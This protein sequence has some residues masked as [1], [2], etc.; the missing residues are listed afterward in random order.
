MKKQLR[1]L[2]F[3]RTQVPIRQISSILI[4]PLLLGASGL[5]AGE[6]W[7]KLLKLAE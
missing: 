2:D 7:L 4:V 1:V 5:T 3:N 6:P